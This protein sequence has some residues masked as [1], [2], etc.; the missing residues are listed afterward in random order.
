M[1]PE[2]SLPHSLQPA[3]CPYCYYVLKICLNSAW[4]FLGGMLAVALSY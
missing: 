3:T 2:G 4:N 1:E